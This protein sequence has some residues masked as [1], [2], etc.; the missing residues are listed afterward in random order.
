MKISLAATIASLSTIALAAP[1][2]AGTQSFDGGIIAVRPVEAVAVVVASDAA[3]RTLT[4]TDPAG[5]RLTFDVPPEISLDSIRAGSLVDVSYVEGQAL[6]I[7]KSGSVPTSVVQSVAVAPRPGRPV[8]LSVRPHRVLGRIRD[9]DR[10]KRALTI[11]GADQQPV[12]LNVAPI[13]DGF[14]Q[15]KPGDSAAIEYTGA[16][17]L[18]ATAHDGGKPGAPRL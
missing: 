2:L 3:A 5:K 6:T 15:L 7:L 18:S 11:V 12:A 17:V 14:D 10:S 8:G 16:I 4:I 13:V 1:A 9:I